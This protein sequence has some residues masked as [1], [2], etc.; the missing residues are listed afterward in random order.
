[1]PLRAL[2]AATVVGT[3]LI[4]AAAVRVGH[5]GGELVYVHNAPAA[6]RAPN[7][8][9]KVVNQKAPNVPPQAELSTM[10]M[11]GDRNPASQTGAG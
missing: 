7:Q 1:M 2:I 8:D 10:G 11:T 5:A 4:S 9:A 6:Y 3:F